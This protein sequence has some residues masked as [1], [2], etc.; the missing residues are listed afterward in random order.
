MKLRVYITEYIDFDLRRDSTELVW[1][2][3]DL[4]LMPHESNS[5]L[6]D[7]NVSLSYNMRVR[8][9]THFMLYSC[10]YIVFLVMRICSVLICVLIIAYI[11]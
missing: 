2:V 3:D 1:E 4:M 8:H 7:T 5:R 9:T 11:T 6:F 10:T